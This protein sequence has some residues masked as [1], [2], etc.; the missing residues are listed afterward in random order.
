[1]K[2][3]EKLVEALHMI[4]F[5]EVRVHRL[6]ERLPKNVDKKYQFTVVMVRK[7][8]EIHP[9]QLDIL[10]KIGLWYSSDMSTCEEVA[11]LFKNKHNT[12]VSAMA[13]RKV[14]LDLAA[15]KTKYVFSVKIES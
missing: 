13:K 5:E 9:V 11:F 14:L 15:Q 12:N 10:D 3:E 6:T 7:T 2:N 4:G 1:M 8:K